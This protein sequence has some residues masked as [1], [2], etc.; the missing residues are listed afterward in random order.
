M[1]PAVTLL[2]LAVLPAVAPA[3]PPL[4]PGEGLTY[5]VSWA[6]IGAGEIKIAAQAEPEITPPRLRVTTTTATKGFARAFLEFNAS[7]E[8]VFDAGT[9]RLKLLTEW[10]RQGKKISEHAV[11]F[12]YPAAQ[13]LYTVPGAPDR[14]RTL[15]LPA[16]EPLDLIGQLVQTRDWNLR[17]GEKRDALVLFNDDFYELTLHATGEEEVRTPLGK[18]KTLVLQPRMERTPPKGMFRKGSTVR[19]WIARDDPRRLPV[20]FEVEFKIGTGVATLIQY[21]PPAKSAP[22]DAKDPRP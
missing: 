4:A 12:D 9:G 15:P 6:G 2:G 7:A 17:P 20:K 13:A 10:S 3:A 16:G 1:R 5:R 14:S 8:S 18:F 22:P 11:A 19:V 21:Q